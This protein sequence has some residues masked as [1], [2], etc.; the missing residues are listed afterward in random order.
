MYAG[1]RRE[2]RQEGREKKQCGSKNLVKNP[3]S[4][5][6]YARVFTRRL[7]VQIFVVIQIIPTYPLPVN[8]MEHIQ[9]FCPIDRTANIWRNVCVPLTDNSIP[10][11]NNALNNAT[12]YKPEHSIKKIWSSPWYH[13]SL[14][15]ILGGVLS[16]FD[17][18]KKCEEITIAKQFLLRI[19][20][21]TIRNSW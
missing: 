14:T 15:C 18:R 3:R 2:G 1:S 9:G 17:K 8:F 20:D 21:V 19:V 12:R 16:F 11:K 7:F 5:V 6:W 13:S 10:M 4:Q